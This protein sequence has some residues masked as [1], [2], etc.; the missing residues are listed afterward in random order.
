VLG[1]FF[2]DSTMDDQPFTA[3][4]GI[5]VEHLMAKYRERIIDLEAHGLPDG[6]ALWEVMDTILTE[7]KRHQA[8]SNSE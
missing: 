1:L 3:P 6:E 4:A 8:P 5:N 7:M 2:Q